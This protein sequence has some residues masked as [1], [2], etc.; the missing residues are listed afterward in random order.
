[1][2]QL[3]RITNL[4]IY[5]SSLYITRIDKRNETNV[6]QQ[7]CIGESETKDIQYGDAVMSI[8]VRITCDIVW[9]MLI[10]Q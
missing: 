4:G 1:M 5:N 10:Y 9:C 6:L 7:T 8:V 3:I 2:K